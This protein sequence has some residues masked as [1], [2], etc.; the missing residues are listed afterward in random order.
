M[1]VEGDVVVLDDPA[2]FA[3]LAQRLERLTRAK[4]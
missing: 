2:D 1:A 3:A 4:V